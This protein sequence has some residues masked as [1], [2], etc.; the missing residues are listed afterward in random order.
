MTIEPRHY[1]HASDRASLANLLDVAVARWWLGGLRSA[2]L[3]AAETHDTAGDI[4]VA[5]G[6]LTDARLDPARPATV[7][8]IL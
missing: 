3:Y 8:M 1:Q 6:T 4:R 2:H 5:P 7:E